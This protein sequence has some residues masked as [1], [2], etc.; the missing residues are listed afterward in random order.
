M[1]KMQNAHR[2]CKIVEKVKWNY[3]SVWIE[4][5]A[6]GYSGKSRI[7]QMALGTYSILGLLIEFF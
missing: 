2:T 4:F 5:H 1:Y 3:Q 6:Q 7:F